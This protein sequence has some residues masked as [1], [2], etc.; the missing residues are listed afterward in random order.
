MLRDKYGFPSDIL[1]DFADLI[2]AEM[3]KNLSDEVHIR[4]R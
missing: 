3:L 1:D 4:F 2:I